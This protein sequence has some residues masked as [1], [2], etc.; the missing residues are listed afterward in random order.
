MLVYK[1]EYANNL[2][3]GKVNGFSDY[4]NVSNST[5]NS[6]SSSSSGNGNGKPIPRNFNPI[7]NGAVNKPLVRNYQ[8]SPQQQPLQPPEFRRLDDN[9]IRLPRG[10]DGSSGF[11][12]KR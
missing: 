11:L 3:N 7:H 4:N 5:N 9:V 12:L 1:T 8:P 2:T 6:I 10:P